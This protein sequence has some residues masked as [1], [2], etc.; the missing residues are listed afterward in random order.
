NA[1]VILE[2]A[3]AEQDAPAKD[4]PDTAAP[5]E[6]AREDVQT[7]AGPDAGAEAGG[8]LPVVWLLSAKSEPGL[9][10]VAR[11]L[12][13][14]ISADTSTG[15]GPVDVAR[16]AHT[17]A[18]GRPAFAYRAVVHGTQPADFLPG[19]AAVAADQPH[20]TVTTGTATAGTPRTVF[21]FPG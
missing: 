15:R 17:L 16:V 2:Q 19:L 21:V 7:A 18:T 12:H 20:P 6:D 8:G 10:A 14:R 5:G 11:R 3:P 13:D 1:H 4:V 9:R